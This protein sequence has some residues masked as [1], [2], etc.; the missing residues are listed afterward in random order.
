MSK[1]NLNKV[2]QTCGMNNVKSLKFTEA[3]YELEFF[4]RSSDQVAPFHYPNLEIL[5][6]KELPEKVSKELEDLKK[7]EERSMSLLEDPTR[8]EEEYVQEVLGEHNE[9]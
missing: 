3:G 7:E 2:I 5:N 1:E 8:F 9:E 6:N 4:P